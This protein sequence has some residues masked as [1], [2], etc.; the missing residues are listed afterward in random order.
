[1]IKF[2]VIFF[3]LFF[4][5]GLDAQ[6]SRE[7]NEELHDSL[8]PKNINKPDLKELCA[9]VD[10][11]ALSLVAF[12]GEMRQIATEIEKQL[13]YIKK[14]EE[15]IMALYTLMIFDYNFPSDDNINLKNNTLLLE[16][17]EKNKVGYEK[18]YFNCLLIKANYH[19]GLYNFEEAINLIQQA[20][21]QKSK[22]KNKNIVA[23]AYLTLAEIYKKI[24]LYDEALL[25]LDNAT[26]TA[27]HTSD[28]YNKYFKY[29]AF[30]KKSELN[31]LKHIDTKENKYLE[32]AKTSLDEILKNDLK[33]RW[34]SLWYLQNGYISYLEK[35]YALSQSQLDKALNISFE[36]RENSAIACRFETLKGLLF[37]K[38]AKEKEGIKLIEKFYDETADDFYYEITIKELYEYYKSEENYIKANFYLE[39]IFETKTLQDNFKYKGAVFTA[40]KKYDVREKQIEIERLEGQAVI[41]KKQNYLILFGVLFVSSIIIS[42]LLFKNRQNKI[43]RL[44]K[45]KEYSENIKLMQ[46]YLYD[47]EAKMHGEQNAI[48]KQQK[49]E[50]GQNIH[51]DVLGSIVALNY[52]IEDYKSKA[53]NEHERNSFHEI[54]LETNSIYTELRN[55]S[56]SLTK[57]E[58]LHQNFNLIAYIENIQNRFS[59]IGLLNIIFDADTKNLETMLTSNIKSE[60]YYL[61]KESVSNTLKHAN[62]TQLIIKI[63]FEK[64]NCIIK[65]SDDGEG[66]KSSQQDGVGLSSIKERIERIDGTVKFESSLHGTDIT[67]HIPI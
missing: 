26:K 18:Q 3:V 23:G 62:A 30:L 27:D 50:I 49:I 44:Q 34:L 13:P 8:K 15:K 7:L 55:F 40:N 12:S 66:L 35:K 54:S 67:A 16:I 14:R 60:I 21:I 22:I 11:K 36:E 51:N 37:I 61:I 56:H 33:D 25:N 9:I 31:I 4:S 17:I 28:Y 10:N 46:E 32:I 6:I 39:K 19:C 20:L 64:T 45:E 24:H 38:T 29:Y 5:L 41:K 48:I 59:E 47:E 42:V 65:I 1:M 52:L 53:T 2:F 57:N 58:N 43:K 63:S